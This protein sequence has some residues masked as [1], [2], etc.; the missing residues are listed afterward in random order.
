MTVA[1]FEGS[2]NDLKDEW[3]EYISLQTRLRHPNVFQLFGI[4]ASQGLYAAIFHE[5]HISFEQTKKAYRVTPTLR[6]YFRDFWY[7]EFE[8]HGS[9]IAFMI[10]TPDLRPSMCT[11]WFH[12]SGKLCIEV[13]SRAQHYHCEINMLGLY[14][15]RTLPLA[16]HSTIR[17]HSVV[18][19]KAGNLEEMA[20]L[21]QVTSDP[22]KWS[23]PFFGYKVSVPT[24]IMPNGWTRCVCDQVLADIGVE[25]RSVFHDSRN[26]LPWATCWLNLRG[27][28]TRFYWLPQVNHIFNYLGL[29]CS[30]C[31]FVDSVEIA[32]KLTDNIPQSLKKIFLFLPDPHAF[33]T[34]DLTRVCYPDSKAEPYWSFDLSGTNHLSSN[35]ASA[36]GLPQIQLEISARHTFIVD[37]TLLNDLHTFYTRKGFNSNS[38]DVAKHLKRPLYCFGDAGDPAP[39]PLIRSYLLP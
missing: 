32:C 27:R 19:H 38:Q 39:S 37:K 16:R 31:S 22:P 5:E 6:I 14:E 28:F 11:N 36:L 7:R 21:P 20:F 34:P 24:T 10:N 12:I 18:K 33:L 1:I 26:E 30:S 23:F 35:Q 13:H 4:T 9:Y 8:T 25:I 3:D 29:E 15:T 17:P 2:E